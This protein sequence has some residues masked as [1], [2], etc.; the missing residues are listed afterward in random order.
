MKDRKARKSR[1]VRRAGSGAL[2]WGGLLTL[3][4]LGGCGGSST[5]E[6]KKPSALAEVTDKG[7]HYEVIL[8]YGTGASPRDMGRAYAAALVQCVPDAEKKLDAI[9]YALV[10]SS[11]LEDIG[12]PILPSA[13]FRVVATT[14]LKDILPQ[15]QEPYRQELE[16]LAD[17][18]ASSEAFEPGDGKLSRTEILAMNL[19]MDIGR[20]EQCCALSVFASRSSTRAPQTIRVLEFPV[21][22]ALLMRRLHS[23]T[24]I[25]NG[26]KSLCL[27]QPIGLLGVVS[28]VN[29]SGIFAAV[30]D[31]PTH[32]DYVSQGRR[33]YP[34]DL[35][36]ALENCASME[37]IAEYMGSP[38][39]AYTYNHVIFM[40]DGTSAGAFENNFSGV[41]P[42]MRRALR[43][44]A[45][46]LNEG[47]LWDEPEALPAV[48]A[49]ALKG[50]DS[51]Y[52][53]GHP[54]PQR[55]SARW[56][57]FRAFMAERPQ[58]IASG[59]LMGLLCRHAGDSVPSRR[60]PGDIY[61]NG[62]LHLLYLSH[63]D[64]TFKAAFLPPDDTPRVPVFDTI[65]LSF[66]KERR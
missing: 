44:S 3:V 50:N 41:G 21:E 66:L 13:L 23:V 54:E 5:E 16:G 25:K 8:D 49:F 52:F 31:S 1:T 57:V 43:T 10:N 46:E 32:Q 39:R 18:L 53:W 24:K 22:Q 56:E 12:I 20:W 14:R 55:N 60:A 26:D 51:S 47:I 27:V 34:F 58:A 48:T 11:M 65:D 38:S 19:G 37:A 64:M 59:D 15:L 62:A 33:S 35:R 30:L 7:S 17:V 63:E 36:Y 6:A 2:L 42:N 9:L 4:L 40:S 28:G 61:S 29:A 45:S